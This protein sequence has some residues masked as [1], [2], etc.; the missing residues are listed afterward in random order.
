MIKSHCLNTN[1][2]TFNSNIIIFVLLSIK[3]YGHFKDLIEESGDKL[4]ALKTKYF[5]FYHI[6]YTHMIRLRTFGLWVPIMLHILIFILFIGVC[7]DQIRIRPIIYNLYWLIGW[8][9]SVISLV[10]T[11]KTG[12]NWKRRLYIMFSLICV[13]N[14]TIVI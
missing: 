3:V 12:I 2:P 7:L 6:K 5:Y 14:V 1:I 10:D 11:V 8:N 13:L 4:K 9:E